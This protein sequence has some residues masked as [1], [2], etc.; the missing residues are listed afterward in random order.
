V[1]DRVILIVNEERKYKMTNQYYAIHQFCKDSDIVVELDSDDWFA[2]KNVLSYL[3]K[4]YSNPN[5][6]LAYSMFKYHPSGKKGNLCRKIPK[7][8]IKKRGYRGYGFAYLG[9]RTFYAG[10]FK[11]IKK[12]DLFYRGKYEKFKDKF[13]P[14]SSDITIFYPMLEMCNG[15]FIY[16]PDVLKI[17]N[18]DRGVTYSQKMKA[19]RKEHVGGLKRMKRYA[20]L[21][22]PLWE[23]Y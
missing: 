16:I 20:S 8:V 11:L 17:M 12:E 5:V 18:R 1:E 9:L 23:I 14:I 10:L 13:T 7:K 15:R 3:N 2:N 4:V 22:F 21:E 6:W 19:I